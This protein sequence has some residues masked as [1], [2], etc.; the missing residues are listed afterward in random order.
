MFIQV[1]YIDSVTKIPCAK[2]PML[3]GPTLPSVRG[4]AG[5]FGV[6]SNM[7]IVINSDSYYE[8]SPVFYGICDDDADLSLSG[9]IK[10]ITKEEYDAAR[11]AEY[12]AR[13]PYPSWIG[14]FNTL[15]WRPPVE[16]PH[17]DTPYHW[18]EQSQS[19]ITPL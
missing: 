6:M 17:D 5:V 10:E 12:L 19:W 7:S 8:T 15:D 1:T 9:V 11:E 18:D 13:Q 14:N 4:L 16:I 3:N 2:A